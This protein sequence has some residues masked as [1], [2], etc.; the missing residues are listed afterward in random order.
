MCT[1]PVRLDFKNKETRIQAEH[2]LRNICKVSC[3][4]PY[5][6]KLRQMLKLQIEEGKKLRDKCFIRNKVDIDNLKIITW[7]RQRTA[8]STWTWTRQIPDDILGNDWVRD[9]STT[10]TTWR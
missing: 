2:T 3:S 6:K 1:V 5:P 8:G 7:P 4:V 9:T 10:T